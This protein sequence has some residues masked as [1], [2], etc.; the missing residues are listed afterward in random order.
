M[1]FERNMMETDYRLS[2]WLKGTR[3]DRPIPE[4][5]AVKQLL[6]SRMVQWLAASLMLLFLFSC[7]G[8][9]P[10]VAD[11]QPQAGGRKEAR[12]VEPGKEPPYAQ[13]TVR[14]LL[15]QKFASASLS[16]SSYGAEIRFKVLGGMLELSRRQG[17]Q[18]VVLDNQTGFR[19]YP[20]KG[21]LLNFENGYYRGVVDVFINPLGVPVVVNEVGLED[22]LKSVVPNEL[23]PKAYP[24]I[25]ALKAQAVAARTFA[26]RELDRNAVHG[27]D[28]YNDS[29][30]QNYR[31]AGSEHELSSRAVDQT[32]GIIAVQDGKPILAMYSSTCGG[33]TEAYHNIFKGPPI[34]YL[35]GGVD[36]DDSASPYHEWSETI[37]ISDVRQSLDSY[38]GVGRL[39]DLEILRKSPAGRTI[40]MRFVGEGGDRVLEG[41]DLR[42][43]L[44]LR[45]NQIDKLEISRSQDGFVE[46]IRV[47]GKGWGHG[48]GLCQTGAVTMARKG[49]EYDEILHHY[50]RDIE[51][52]KWNGV[53]R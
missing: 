15:K 9:G 24:Q 7:G 18:W 20:T 27:F 49:K 46:S 22:Y 40:S 37:R 6:G 45:S 44:G 19:L 16:G 35:A 31:G 51:L 5:A 10:K 33:R 30:A 25:E 29:R 23:G 32:S 14:I 53:R 52:V 11:Q 3:D 38:A 43:A 50:Y 47:S 8:G 21:R 12:K 17:N 1:L 34:P 48:V 4:D 28:M 2:A 39:K 41:N 13:P 36:C 26:V 42:F